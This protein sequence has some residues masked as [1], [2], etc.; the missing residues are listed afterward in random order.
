MNSPEFVILCEL[1]E[2]D[3][4]FVSGSALARKLGMSRVGVWTHM[5]KLRAQGF[6]FEAVRRRGYRISGYP[7]GINPLLVQACLKSRPKPV[8]LLWLATVDSTNEEAERQLAAG[9]ATPFVV[10][11]RQQSLGRGRFGRVWHSEDTANLYASFVFRP[12]LEPG[13]MTTFTL[14]MG[15][16]LCDLVANFCR[17]QPGIK[18]PN[19]LYFDGRKLGGM[20]TEAR[21]DADQI[22][23][24]VFGLGLNVNGPP[25]SL[26]PALTRQATT[27]AQ[28]T[29]QPVALNRLTAAIVGRVLSA[30]EQFVDGSHRDA[31]ADLWN[32][33]DLLRG[34]PVSLMQGSRR[35]FGVAAGIDDE[36]ALLIRGKNGPPQRFS[37]GEVTLETN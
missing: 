33:Y 24:L 17:I 11:A 9:R 31:F 18:W 13:R 29:G 3:P 12:H 30:Y 8:D 15:A 1:L 4:N 2:G 26:P 28:C 20:L 10:I 7:P 14:W 27:L 16:N 21:I 23:D 19:D 32:R 25:G 6:E 34:Q 35:V 22:R 36:G 37:A 5:G